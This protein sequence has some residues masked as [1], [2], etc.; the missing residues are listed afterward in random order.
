MSTKTEFD[1]TEVLESAAN[2]F[3]DAMK[4]GVK[5]QEEVVKWWTNALDGGCG[6]Q[7]TDFRKR[8]KQL[9]D[10]AVPAAQ[11]QAQ[12][13]IKLIDSNSRRS[14]DLLRKALDADQEG[15]AAGFTDAARKL[16]EESIAVV[17]ENIETLT[18]TNVKML[19]VWADLLRKSVEQGESAVKAAASKA[20]QASA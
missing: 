9:F 14:I 19:E 18:Q 1:A 6:C 7:V 2:A 3:G 15:V 17:K 8:A 4:A 5:A 16:W 12:D 11:K 10:E 20:K 13:W